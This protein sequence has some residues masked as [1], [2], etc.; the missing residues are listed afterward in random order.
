MEKPG[1]TASSP[2]H[3]AIADVYHQFVDDVF[4]EAGDSW[5]PATAQLKSAARLVP[6]PSNKGSGADPGAS[7]GSDEPP[8][9]TRNFLKQFLYRKGAEFGEVNRLG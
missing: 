9:E 2:A 6:A 8:S 3:T 5:S 1:V 7:S 4:Y